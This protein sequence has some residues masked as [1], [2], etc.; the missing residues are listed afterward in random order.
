MEAVHSF[1]LGDLIRASVSW[2]ED[3]K[4]ENEKISH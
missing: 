1:A 4:T 3:Y 2:A